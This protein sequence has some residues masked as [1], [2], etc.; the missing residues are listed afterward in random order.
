MV[1][2]I[3]EDPLRQ[4]LGHRFRHGILKIPSSGTPQPHILVNTFILAWKTVYI[5]VPIHNGR[6]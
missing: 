5:S 4:R 3:W 1:L 2:A 6:S